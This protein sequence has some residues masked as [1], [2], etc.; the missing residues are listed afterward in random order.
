MSNGQETVGGQLPSIGM[1]NPLT[2]TH[3]DQIQAAQRILHDLLPQLDRASSC[4]V[5]GCDEL[6]SRTRHLAERLSKFVQV[7]F[8]NGRPQ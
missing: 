4:N 7:Y 2:A 1:I 6:R 3:Y 8:P 5:P